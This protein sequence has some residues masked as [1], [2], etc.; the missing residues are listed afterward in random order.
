MKKKAF[1]VMAIAVCCAVNY[2]CTSDFEDEAVVPAAKRTAAQTWSP[3]VLQ[4]AR[5]LGIIIVDE[6]R[7]WNNLTDEDVV[8]YLNL[9]TEKG[10]SAF[11]PAVAPAPKPM[12]MLRRMSSN[13]IEDVG[14]TTHHITWTKKFECF[15]NNMDFDVLISITWGMNDGRAEDPRGSYTIT[16]E[17]KNWE[18]DYSSLSFGLTANGEDVD[19]NLDGTITVK[20]INRGSDEDD[21]DKGVILWVHLKGKAG[22]NN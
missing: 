9:L 12:G 5:E 18:I 8:F 11:T 10:D 14:S 19:Y 1:L 16:L 6:D 13:T 3:E 21:G 4:R 17:D 2:S 20:E 15:Y 22:K 7:Q